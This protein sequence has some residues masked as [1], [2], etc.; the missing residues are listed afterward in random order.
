METPNEIVS[1]VIEQRRVS[2]EWFN[3]NFY[4]EWSEVYR[5]LKARVKP[6]KRKNDKGEEVEDT[7]RTNSQSIDWSIAAASFKPAGGGGAAPPAGLSAQ[8]FWPTGR[9]A[10][11]RSACRPEALADGSVGGGPKRLPTLGIG[12]LRSLQVSAR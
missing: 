4:G 9:S 12:S 10:E 11:A 7:S 6:L 5:N 3:N 2:L 1:S 8:R